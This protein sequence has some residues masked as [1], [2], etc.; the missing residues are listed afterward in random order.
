MVSQCAQPCKDAPPVAMLKMNAM[1]EY[2][3][4]DYK[5]SSTCSAVTGSNSYD[6]FCWVKATYGG[7][8]GWLPAAYIGTQV[9][10]AFCDHS[11]TG[12]SYVRSFCDKPLQHPHFLLHQH[13][14]DIVIRQRSPLLTTRC[15]YHVTCCAADRCA[16][17]RCQQK[18]CYKA[19]LCNPA[20]GIC[21]PWKAAQAGTPCKAQPDG[22]CNGSGQCKTPA[23]APGKYGGKWARVRSWMERLQTGARRMQLQVLRALVRT[24][25]IEL[26]HLHSSSF[27]K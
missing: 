17:V 12:E 15:W 3:G 8:I 21:S 5:I 9:T 2:W 20:T 4:P 22:K 1:F 25:T 18:E 6:G 24:G 27:Q 13:V 19:R 10:S 14:H 26:C 23:V 7:A 16:G 11:G